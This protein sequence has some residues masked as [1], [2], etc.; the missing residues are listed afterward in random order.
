MANVLLSFVGRN[1]YEQCVYGDTQTAQYSTVVR[2]VQDAICQLHC[3]NWSADDRIVIFLTPNARLANWEGATYK[4]DP[5]DTRGLE[6]TL[7]DLQLNPSI[8]VQSI[9][10]G[11]DEKEI[12]QNFSIIYEA[13]NEGDLVYLDITNAF[14]SIPVFA[15]VLSN[16]AEF[17]KGVRLKS[18]FYGI[19]ERLGSPV[20][21]R[22]N[23]PNPADRRVP[24]LDLKSIVQLQDWTSAANDFLTHG[25]TA[26]LS[27]MAHLTTQSNRA[28]LPKDFGSNLEALT[29]VFSTVR[30]K[31]IADGDVFTRLRQNIED[32]EQTAG[33]EP[34]VPIL[35]KVR[36]S[37]SPF[38]QEDILNGFRA[39]EWCI[40]HQFVQQ[41]ITLF[42]E[43]IVS[44][45]CH[46]CQMDFQRREHR[47]L[48]ERTFQ[49]Y[50]RSKDMLLKEP[51]YEKVRPL[52]REPLVG[53]LHPLYQEVSFQY[54]NDINHGGYLKGSKE[55]FEFVIILRRKFE[56]LKKIITL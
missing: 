41:G 55:A 34:L 30:G 12:Q 18:I 56:E 54:R 50:G 46:R 4:D 16:Y 26:A 45:I 37:L 39:I 3:R 33:L 24:I 11:M 47:G 52:F 23:Y 44:Y 7:M 38:K 36:D 5:N 2:F 10:E 1:R 20:D 17:L 28:L 13:L 8:H 19:F 21:V 53:K 27:R 49:L 9:Y 14:R 31:E 25:N 15:A 22:K 32:I 48:I 43:T 40:E 42:R 51:D 6:T 35:Q 29:G